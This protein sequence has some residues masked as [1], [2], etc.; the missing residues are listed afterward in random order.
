VKAG[1]GMLVESANVAFAD[2]LAAWVVSC[3]RDTRLKRQKKSKP[4][5]LLIWRAAIKRRVNLL[6][7]KGMNV[8]EPE[9]SGDEISFAAGDIIILGINLFSSI[10]K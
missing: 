9:A 10:K 6:A 7:E 4:A 1:I 3:E 8:Q 2:L 5:D